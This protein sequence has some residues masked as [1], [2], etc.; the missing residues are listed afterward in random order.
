M[1]LT[2]QN[3]ESVFQASV[4]NARDVVLA[5]VVAHRTTPS[6]RRYSGLRRTPR[7]LDRSM[8]LDHVELMPTGS[9]HRLSRGEGQPPA[10]CFREPQIPSRIWASLVMSKIARG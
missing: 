4:A 6:K 1:L 10:T 3:R 7:A 9:D 8:R 5:A 2:S